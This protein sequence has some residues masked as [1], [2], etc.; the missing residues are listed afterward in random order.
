VVE[1]GVPVVAYAP[2]PQ[3]LGGDEVPGGDGHG[4]QH[5]QQRPAK[6]VELAEEVGKTE[7]LLHGL[8]P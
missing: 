8:T 5:Y 2:L 1:E 7:G 4:R 3:R 6:T